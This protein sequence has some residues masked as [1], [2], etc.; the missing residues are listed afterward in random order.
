MKI[1]AVDTS[2]SPVSVAL[3]DN[4]RLVGELYL[5]IKTTH[6]QTLMPL[7]ESILKT[8]NTNINDIDIFAVNAGPGS[9]TGV[10]IGVASIKG[11]SMPLNKPCASVSTLESMAYCMPRLIRISAQAKWNFF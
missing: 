10:R 4:S 7:I 1:L 3:T 2:A 8:T 6:S 5:N 9:F 11:L